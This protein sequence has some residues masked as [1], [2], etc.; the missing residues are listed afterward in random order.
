MELPWI[1]RT[2]GLDDF[3]QTCV[4]RW[5]LCSTESIAFDTGPRGLPK[6]SGHLRSVGPGQVTAE[7]NHLGNVPASGRSGWFPRIRERAR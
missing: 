2:Q 7:A 5:G 3:Q 1:L 6:S 4:I